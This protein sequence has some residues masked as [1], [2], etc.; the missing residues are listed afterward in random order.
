M[1]IELLLLIVR[2]PV[3]QCMVGAT[4]RAYSNLATPSEMEDSNQQKDD[5]TLLRKEGCV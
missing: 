1:P 5:D 2:D 3:I 4:G